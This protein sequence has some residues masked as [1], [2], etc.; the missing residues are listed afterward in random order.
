M[1]R[2]E[3]ARC[4]D[5]VLSACTLSKTEGDFEGATLGNEESPTECEEEATLDRP[6]FSSVAIPIVDGLSG[7]TV[8]FSAKVQTRHVIMQ[9]AVCLRKII[10]NMMACKMYRASHKP[11]NMHEHEP[12]SGAAAP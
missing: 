11:V 1:L 5:R 10:Q 6:L 3:I 9:H 4:V 7:V 12:A 2:F 8:K